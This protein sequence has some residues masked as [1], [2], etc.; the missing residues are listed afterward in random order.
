MF[1]KSDRIRRLAKLLITQGR[2][3]DG[4]TDDGRTLEVGRKT[5][6]E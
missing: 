5:A 3:M 2:K 1:S 4:G 6:N